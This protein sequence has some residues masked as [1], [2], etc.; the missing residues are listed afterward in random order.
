MRAVDKQIDNNKECARLHAAYGE[1][2]REMSQ[3]RYAAFMEAFECDIRDDAF[4]Y[5]PVA[6][7]NVEAMQKG[8]PVKWLAM[9]TPKG[10]MLA[11]FTSKEE[12]A[13]H[14]AGNSVGVKL[15]AFVR[16]ALGGKDCA[17]ILV[18]PLDGHHGIPVERRNLELLAVRSGLAGPQMPR[19]HPGV[20]SNAV[21]KLW[22]IAVGVPTAVYDVSEEV[23]SLGGMDRLLKPIFDAWNERV[24]AN[25]KEFAEPIEY[26]KAVLKD[27]VSK[28]FVYGAMALKHPDHALDV[29]VDECIDAIPDLREDIAQNVD[30]YLILLSDA[31]RSD[32]AEPNEQHVQ[33]LLEANVGIIAFGAFNF[34]LGW[35]MAKDAESRGVMELAELRDRQ[36]KWIEDFRAKV[37]EQVRKQQ[38]KANG[39]EKT[40]NEDG[41]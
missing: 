39:E 20:V 9:N 2:R 8:G 23:K 40:G 27:V 38:E 30:E 22:D 29:D 33:L 25:P 37:L 1:M 10:R 24:K 6:D 11:L 21:Y 18:N 14:P 32:L 41:K 12:V 19:M 7:E 31:T 16:T 15:S 17:G 36:Q 35:G 28:G 26:V 34:G 4:A 3:P 5:L 13:R